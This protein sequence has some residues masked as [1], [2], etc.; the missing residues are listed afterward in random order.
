[1]CW[2][3]FAN[4][5]DKELFD[6][7]YP[8]LL[9][10]HYGLFLYLLLMVHQSCVNFCPASNQ[11]FTNRCVA[12]KSIIFQSFH[13]NNFLLRFYLFGLHD[14]GYTDASSIH[15]RV[16]S[17]HRYYTDYRTLKILGRLFKKHLLWFLFSLFDSRIPKFDDF[18]HLHACIQ[19]NWIT[20]IG[21]IL[22]TSRI[23]PTI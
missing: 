7:L 6:F 21:Q 4:F 1:M 23:I 2:E 10:S 17:L 16:S 19:T 13:T 22:A 18:I 12:N 3:L 8:R 20:I 5:S 11:S 15:D 9:L 14:K